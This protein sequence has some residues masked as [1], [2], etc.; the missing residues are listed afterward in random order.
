MLFGDLSHCF[1]PRLSYADLLGA[2][3]VV[4]NALQLI[5]VHFF[6][7]MKGL[8]L[9]VLCLL[10]VCVTRPPHRGRSSHA[11]LAHPSHTNKQEY[12]C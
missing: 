6:I 3:P 9:L 2:I 12:Q 7:G 4:Q 10:V 1:S 8:S 11:Y 5:I